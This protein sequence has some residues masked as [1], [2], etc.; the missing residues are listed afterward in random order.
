MA[1]SER[2]LRRDE[3]LRILDE[4]HTSIG[5]RL[6][7]LPAGRLD[8]PG[9]GGG[10]WTPKDLAGHLA[11]WDKA[12]LDTIEDAQA[13]RSVRINEALAREG[14]DGFNDAEVQRKASLTGPEALAELERVHR[15]LVEAIG[16]LSDEAWAAP[17]PHLEPRRS[18]GSMLG[19]VLGAP[20]HPFMHPFAHLADLD[21]SPLGEPD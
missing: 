4:G 7:A 14:L 12:G 17:V 10:D 19:G 8:E 21:D 20:G 15:A 3:A 16:R 5:R 18:L 2:A 13:G 1:D 6:R 9:I 11:T